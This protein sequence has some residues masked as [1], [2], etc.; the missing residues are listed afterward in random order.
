MNMANQS[1][2]NR[3]FLKLQDQ[4]SSLKKEVQE[5]KAT[6]KKLQQPL[7]SN[8][9][10]ELFRLMSD[11]TTDLLWAKNTNNEYVFVNKAMC[12]V[13]LNA[14]DVYEPIGKTDMFFADRERNSHPENKAWHTFGEICRDTDT[15]VLKSGK[16]QQFDEYGN[17]KGEFLFLDVHKAPIFNADKKIIGTVGSGRIVTKEKQAEENYHNIFN[18]TNEGIFIHDKETGQILEINDAVL[19]MYGYTYNEIT[20]LSVVDL[21]MGKSPYSPKEIKE[22]IYKTVNIGPQNFEWLAK[23]KS[24]KLFWTSVELKHANIGGKERVL[25][26][27]KDIDRQKKTEQTLKEREEL[28]RNLFD[29]SP[30][31]ILLEDKNGYILDLNPAFTKT[32]QYTRDELIG[33]HVSVLAAPHLRKKEIDEDIAKIIGGQQLSHEVSAVQKDGTPCIIKLNEKRIKL[34]DGEYGILSIAE[35]ITE[36]KKSEDTLR[37]SENRYRQ[38]F[39]KLPYGGEVIDTTGRILECSQSTANMLGYKKEELVGKHLTEIF[40]P[41][42]LEVYKQNFPAVLKGKPQIGEI[43]M[44]RKNGTRINILRAGHPLYEKDS[45]KVTSVLAVNVNITERKTA[46]KQLIRKLTESEEVFKITNA[47]NN[48]NP[49]DEIYKLIFDSFDKIFGIKRASILMFDENDVMQFKAWCGISAKYR[50]AVTGHSPWTPKD[51]N[52]SPFCLPNVRN[53]KSLIKYGNL[54]KEEN[55]VGMAFIPLINKGFVIG[56]F[57]LYSDYERIFDKNDLQ[58]AQTIGNQIVISNN[59]KHDEE[60][61]RRSEEKYR[62][63]FMDD[64]TGDYLTSTDGKIID[65]NPAFMEIFGFKN[66]KEAQQFDLKN[67]YPKNKGRNKFLA[68]I[69]KEKKVKNIIIEMKRVDGEP[70]F[71][72]E[73]VTGIFDKKGKL[74][75]LRGY[76]I[77]I[78]K[79]FEAEHAL[80][81]S[82]EHFRSLIENNNDCIAL[83]N[84]DGIIKYISPAVKKILGHTPKSLINTSS[85]DLIHTEDKAFASKKFMAIITS[86]GKS[87][88]LKI[89]SF[90]KK[91]EVVWLNTTMTNLL[92]NPSVSSIV[93]NFND[94]SGQVEIEQELKGSEESYRGLF[95]N[96]T[97][98]IYILDQNS[99]F[100]D[101][102]KSAEKM[103]GYKKDYLIS[104]TPEI[105]SAPDKNDM[106]KVASYIELAFKGGSPTFE[107]W[108]KNKSG[109][110]FPMEV[111]LSLG[112]YFGKKVI[113]AFAQDITERKKAEDTLKISEKSYRGLFDNATDAIYIQDFEGKFL[114][115]NK[116]V[117]KM[118]G[119]DRSFFIGKS[120]AILSAPGKNDLEHVGKLIQKTVEGQ[121][122]SFEFWGIRKNGEIFPKEVR[123]KRGIYFGQD[124]II[125]FAQD[126]SA[127][128]QAEE[129]RV[130]LEAQIQH[131][132]KLKSLG[133]LSG[134]IAHDFNNLLTGILGNVGLAELE[135]PK[136]SP[137]LANLKRIETSSIRAA[138]L[139]RQLL[140]YS[141]RGKFVVKAL[142]LNEVVEEMGSL[143]VTSISKKVVLKYNFYDDLP[144]VEVDTAQIRQV[145][146]NLIMNASDAIGKKSGII[147]ITTGAMK[148]KDAYLH[149]TFLNDNLTEG[150]YVY[151][152]VSDTGAGMD[153]ETQAKIFDP[154]FTTKFTGRGLGLAAVLGIMR[155]HNGAIKIYSE[156]GKGTSFKVLFPCSDKT[157]SPLNTNSEKA[158]PWK[159]EGTILII[160]DEDTIRALGRQALEKAGFKV[161]TAADGR[162]GIKIFKKEKKSI[163]AVLLDMTMPHMSGE[164]TFREMRLINTNVKVLLSSGYNEQEA[165]NNFAGKGLAGFLQKPYRTSDLISKIKEVIDGTVQ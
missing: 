81:K 62:R 65:C 31:A 39:D 142:D 119:Y 149:T 25:A 91:G 30:T 38:L 75:K 157:A 90:N 67:L 51:K 63:F 108:G 66:L 143:L 86:P 37:E 14:K 85:F 140:A 28:Y 104:N 139:C 73:N 150:V 12:D 69:K 92:K 122:Q 130:K 94:I 118:Y 102:N 47:V 8:D 42:D 45:K 33:K 164:E 155:G 146:M 76:L 84:K 53:D 160:D 80:R 87:T 83:Y 89:R 127:R 145:V 97:E 123:L 141:G 2:K 101:V 50:K 46:E 144:A 24:G 165:T 109:F 16:P 161:I 23:T 71:I 5:L 88:N 96:A 17:I 135:L 156:P 49:I 34:P 117:E 154:F 20:K 61:L 54:F 15:K 151:I 114:D 6:R 147:S 70:I 124:A 99:V 132:Q 107:F 27:V 159:A 134:G 59:R 4:I 103:Y 10:I 11:N 131:T 68:R 162:E 111:H 74:Q 120:P 100:L 21:S 93:V 26:L 137:A 29:L 79:Q 32:R 112:N 19:N 48:D 56:K 57:M 1:A 60:A 36:Q 9:P 58:L 105:V 98:A 115:V 148:C 158:Q 128:K 22:W 43:T 78:T 64:L 40:E 121:P 125:A 116:T 82:E 41:N 95:D 18:T 126:I 129:E 44:I 55:I 13:L 106:A 72:T 35:D 113:I 52:P 152:E 110:V 7:S 138:D 153:K 3:D 163:T 133:V 77:D 136:T